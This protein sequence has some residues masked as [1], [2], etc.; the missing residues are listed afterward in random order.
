MSDYIDNCPHCGAS[1]TGDE[2][3]ENRREMFGGATH[4]SRARA[5]YDR[6]RDRTDH[7]ECPD[8]GGRI[9]RDEIVKQSGSGFRTFDMLVPEGDEG[10]KP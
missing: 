6:E 3:P 9:E 2:I 8:C 7:F 4:F 10:K 1:L 5:I